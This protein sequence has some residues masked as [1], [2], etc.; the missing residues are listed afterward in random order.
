MIY[1]ILCSLLNFSFFLV[2][3]TALRKFPTAPTASWP[4]LG[5]VSPPD[6]LVHL[7]TK[8]VND[9]AHPWMPPRVGDQRGPCPGLNVLASHGYLP[10]NGVAT[11]VQLIN[12]VQEGFNME[13]RLAKIFVYST[14]IVNGNPLTNLLSIGG[15][16]PLTGPDPPSPAVVAGLNAGGLFEGDASMSRA[17]GYFGNSHE[18]N[19]GV[20]DQFKSFSANYGNGF[21]NFT[22]APKL[23]HHLF[24]QSRQNNPEVSFTEFRWFSAHAKSVFPV[25]FF[26]DGRNY[27]GQLSMD[28]AEAFFKDGRFP[29]D[30]WR[31]PAPVGLEGMGEVSSMSSVELISF[32][33]L[34]TNVINMAAKDLYPNPTGLLRTNLIKNMRWLFEA[35][36]DPD[37]AEIFPYGRVDE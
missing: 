26:V 37:C 7:G 1:Y 2:P 10:R 14:L 30:F 23:R 28:A 17:D 5:P 24:Q 3:V 22:V 27:T 9:A 34:Y 35:V 21:Y 6:P 13:N 31:A 33:R 11:T 8:L 29:D 4:C 20:F 19:T 16:T 18:F 12:A 15:M 25:N 32:C 36:D